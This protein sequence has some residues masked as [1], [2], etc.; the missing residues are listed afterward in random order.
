MLM[1]HVTTWEVLQITTLWYLKSV[2]SLLSD[3][4]QCHR[5]E[6]FGSTEPPCIA[7]YCLLHMYHLTLHQRKRRRL[8]SLHSTERCSLPACYYLKHTNLFCRKVTGSYER[9]SLQQR[10]IK[11]YYG[12]LGPGGRA[13]D[14][15]SRGPEFE[16]R[17]L[18]NFQRLWRIFE[19]GNHMSHRRP[20][21]NGQ[22]RG[23][24]DLTV[25][26]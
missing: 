5:L 20:S 16:S 14:S 15:R 22:L 3:F 2:V 4:P 8:L 24:C 23:K 6:L 18:A 17:H 25:S 21:V 11:A 19:I 26:L 12:F 7:A 13:E 10:V 9:Y 1:W